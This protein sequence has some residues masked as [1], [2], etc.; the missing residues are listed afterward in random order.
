M[1]REFWVNPDTGLRVRYSVPTLR[2]SASLIRT[3]GRIVVICPKCRRKFL[4]D[5]G[6]CPDCGFVLPS[7]QSIFDEPSS[8]EPITVR[9]RGDRGERTGSG[10]TP[11]EAPLPKRM[12]EPIRAPAPD[13]DDGSSVIPGLSL[14]RLPA[15]VED[16]PRAES[17][18]VPA[19]PTVRTS[20]AD[21]E[22]PLP[23][24][25]TKPDTPIPQIP[26]V[27]RVVRGERLNAVYPLL[28][29]KNVIGRSAD[30]PA[31][32]DLIG[33][34]SPDQIWSSRQHAIVTVSGRTMVIEDM[35]SLNGT[36][37]NRQR[38]HP[39]QPRLLQP[40]DVIQIGTVQ[41]RVEG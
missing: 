8:E 6:S 21:L 24:D 38:I 32:I 36:F 29:G 4:A 35:N 23:A 10:A 33:Q 25:A 2:S 17:G 13:I 27:L 16:P 12:V 5:S 20:S 37:V 31:D 1:S 3:S 22:P 41:L 34:E 30:K 19:G 40:G 15:G 11:P 9:D 18:L 14:V 39:G 7:P 28:D 26:L